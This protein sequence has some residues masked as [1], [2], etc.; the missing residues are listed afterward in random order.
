MGEKRNC[1][2]C[3]SYMPNNNIDKKLCKKGLLGKRDS[4]ESKCCYWTELKKNSLKNKT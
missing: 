2:T 3:M 4:I 1:L